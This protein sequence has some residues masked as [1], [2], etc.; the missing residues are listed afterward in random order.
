MKTWLRAGLCALAATM[1]FAPQSRVES[2]NI[3]SSPPGAT[4]EINGLVVGVTPLH[5][6]YPGGYF[7]KTKTV[8]STRLEHSMHAR[9]YKDGYT[10]QEVELTE[11]PFE[12]IALNGRE[13]GRYWLLKAKQIE[14]T[15][16]PTAKVF[17]GSVRTSSARGG[18]VDY[19]PELSAERVVEI[20][21]PAIV[22]LRDDRGWG[23]G[24]AV[25]DAGVIATNHH[26]VEGGT[27][28]TV[29]FSDASELPGRV[30]YIDPE[31]DLALVKVEG[32]DLPM[33]RWQIIRTFVQDRP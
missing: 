5:V 2:L 9:I 8:F 11:G 20:A 4:A 30:A 1:W 10:V 3:T 7:H 21:S 12:W 15:L 32:Q 22:K 24:F 28:V 6:N 26:V 17:D 25:T 23:T 16:R 18:T 13:Y 31:L 14:A 29:I 33:F 19:R 27:S